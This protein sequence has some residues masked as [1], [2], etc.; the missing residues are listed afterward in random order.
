MK[1]VN[2]YYTLTDLIQSIIISVD[3]N[4][5]INVIKVVYNKV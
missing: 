2:P 5:L 4:P 1:D 3:N